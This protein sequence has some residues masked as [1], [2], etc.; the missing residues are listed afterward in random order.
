[1]TIYK[2]RA[3]DPLGKEVAEFGFYE[4]RG[5]AVKRM[6]D[7]NTKAHSSFVIEIREIHVIP[8]SYEIHKAKELESAGEKNFYELK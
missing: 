3:L 1:M 6:H 2:V 7:V 8:S 5:D 4:D